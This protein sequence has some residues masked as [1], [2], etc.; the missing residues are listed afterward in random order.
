M[1]SRHIRL[2]SLVVLLVNQTTAVE[3]ANPFQDLHRLSRTTR[4]G[5]SRL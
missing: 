1:R 4:V 3:V 5:R 2:I